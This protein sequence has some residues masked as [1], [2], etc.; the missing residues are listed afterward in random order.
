MITSDRRA[1]KVARE[2]AAWRPGHTLP[3]AFYVDPDVYEFDLDA[4]FHRQWLFAGLEAELGRPGDWFT[5][6]VGPSSIVVLRDRAGAIR[7]FHNTCRHRGSRICTKDR[8]R[9]PSLVCPYHQWT[10]ALDGSL[11]HARDMPVEFDRSTHGLKPVHVER[12]AGTIFVCLADA[13]PDFSDHRSKLEPLL[14]PHDLA[15]AKLAAESTLVEKGN[16]KLVME[17]SRECHHCA[18]RH[19]ELMHTLL[20]SFDFA[21]GPMREFAAACESKGL[22]NGP[23]Q[24]HGF[25]AARIP[26]VGGAVSTTMDGRPAVAKL[27]GDT[28]DGDIGSLRWFFFPNAFMHVLGDYAFF[29]RLLPRGPM[30]TEVRSKFLVHADAV[31]GIDYDVERLTRVWSVTNEQDRG[32]VEANQLGVNSIGY[33]PGPYHPVAE[34]AVA[35]FVDWYVEEASGRLAATRPARAAE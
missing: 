28:T 1:E 4:V 21:S 19:P 33:E 22:R 17:N 29:F 9:G 31:A 26:F 18:V 11:V 13:P 12:L 10:Y 16:W 32:L 34:R 35:L 20:E 23:V 14:A 5:L 15:A 2:L 6:D 7:A 27:L 30:E 25:R 3:R 8:G 24:G